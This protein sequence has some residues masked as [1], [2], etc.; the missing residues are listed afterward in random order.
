VNFNQIVISTLIKDLSEYY[1]IGF[2]PAEYNNDHKKLKSLILEYIVKEEKKLNCNISPLLC[3]LTYVPISKLHS[4]KIWKVFPIFEQFE[5]LKDFY[6]LYHFLFG[7]GM[8][9]YDSMIS[10]G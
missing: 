7:E 8:L 2:P 4:I 5:R 1:T 3:Q 10:L 6:S 9:E